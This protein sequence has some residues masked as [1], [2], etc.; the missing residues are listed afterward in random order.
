M[1]A[2]AGAQR[3][4]RPSAVSMHVLLAAGMA[5]TAV[6][7]PPSREERVPREDGPEGGAVREQAAPA[8]E[9]A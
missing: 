9:A 7:T 6:S 4:P 8:S 2:P 3:H 5:A 1:S